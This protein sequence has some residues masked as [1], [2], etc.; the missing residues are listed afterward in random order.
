MHG[1]RRRN[2]HESEFIQAVCEVARS[3]FPLLEDRVE[4]REAKI[5][6]RMTEPDRVITFRVSWEDDSARPTRII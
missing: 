6:E 2:Q 3:I 4:Y 1:L 5:L